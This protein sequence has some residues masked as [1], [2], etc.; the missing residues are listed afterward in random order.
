MY[1]D[2]HDGYGSPYVGSYAHD[3]EGCSDDDIDTV[4]DGYPDAYWNID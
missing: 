3:E 4:F 2:D 1:Y